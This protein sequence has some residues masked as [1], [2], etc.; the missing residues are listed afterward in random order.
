MT[1]ETIGSDARKRKD[2]DKMEKGKER[3]GKELG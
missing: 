3:K 1:E 2:K